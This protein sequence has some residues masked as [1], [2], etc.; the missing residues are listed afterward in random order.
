[1]QAENKMNLLTVLYNEKNVSRC[2]EYI[3]CLERNLQ[4]GMID[5]IHV[6]YDDSGDD[7]DGF[8]LTYLKTRPVTIRYIHGRPSYNDCFEY[9]NKQFPDGRVIL[10]NADIFF[11]ET[12]NT[13]KTYDLNNKFLALTRYDVMTNGSIKKLTA[14][15]G[16]KVFDNIWSQDVWIFPTPLKKF[17]KNASKIQIGVYECD[18][19]IAA[20]A[21]DAGLVV[22]NPCLTIRC[23]HLHMSQVRSY[24][25]KD[26]P[27]KK[28]PRYGVPWTRLGDVMK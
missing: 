18:T 3:V 25:R 17:N 7:K 16:G 5:N 2:T 11:D 4:H 10:A 19:A 26:R 28:L 24:D 14:T 20:C 12:L 15:R 22:L 9:A 23:Y 21:K 8:L 1:V 13:I 6:L 27:Y